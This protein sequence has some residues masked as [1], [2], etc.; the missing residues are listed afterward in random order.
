MQTREAQSKRR[1]K[2]I[3]EAGLDLFIRKGYAATRITDIARAVGMSTG[4]LFHYFPSKEKLYETLI[5]YGVSGPM[6]M[7]D[8][9]DKEPL[10]FF[11]DAAR[12][13]FDYIK[14]QPFTAKMFLLMGQAALTEET[15]EGAKAL[16]KN[17]DAYTPTAQLIQRG[18]KQG[19]L[20]QGDP[21]ALA[22]AFWSAIQGVVQQLA[23]RPDLPSPRSEWI[24]DIIR[25]EK[26]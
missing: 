24:V 11:E 9:A 1:R 8:A 18:Q 21:M 20:R 25:R 22:L 26:P 2:Q 19:T 14:T 4:L 12:D 10:A 6:D 5:Q 13:I 15:P 17:F 23:L 7:L 3:L 16:L